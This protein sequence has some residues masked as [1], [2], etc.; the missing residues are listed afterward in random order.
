MGFHKR[1]LDRDRIVSAFKNGGADGVVDLYKADS[2]QQPSDSHIC[3]YI[4]KI[5]CKEETIE[6]K[7]HLIDTYMMQLLE[8]LYVYK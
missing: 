3:N 5:M 1:H 2:I 4:E 8:G 7:K 6:Y